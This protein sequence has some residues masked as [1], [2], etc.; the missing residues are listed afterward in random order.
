[1]TFRRTATADCE[2]GGQRIRAGDKVV[3]SFTSANRDEAVF[4]DPDRFDP[5]RQPNPHLVFGHGPHFCLGAHLARVQMRALFTEVLARTSTLELR[6]ASRPTCGP[7]SSGASNGSRWP[8]P[9]DHLASRG[10]LGDPEQGKGQGRA[11]HRVGQRQRQP[12][13]PRQLARSPAGGRVTRVDSTTLRPSRSSSR[14]SSQDQAHLAGMFLRAA[15][16][17]CWSRVRRG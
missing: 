16:L 15:I 14:G 10:A 3:V 17:C 11:E 2:L 12:V 9:P 6:R 8:G 4:A 7:T 1:M 5:R 13:P